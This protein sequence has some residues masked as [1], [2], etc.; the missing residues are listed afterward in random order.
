MK[1]I[2]NT[3]LSLSLAIVLGTTSTAMAGAFQLF[4]QSAA[5]LGT[6]QATAAAGCNDPATEYTN[7]AGMVCFKSPTVTQGLEIIGLNIKY[8]G[9]TATKTA[10]ITPPPVSGTTRADATVAI[11]NIHFVLPIND[12]LFYGAGFSVPFGLETNYSEDSVAAQYATKSQMQNLNFSQDLAYAFN[13]HFSF[14]AGI[15]LQQFEGTFNT[16]ESVASSMLPD[17]NHATSNAI[18]WH[19][20]VLYQINSRTRFGL[21][22]HAKVTQKAKGTGTL[23]NDKTRTSIQATGPVSTDFIL[24]AW[25]SFGAYHDINK[26]WAIMSTVNYTYW[27]SVKDLALKG[28]L[29]VGVPSTITVPLN[30]RNTFEISIGTTYK[31]TKK[32]TGKFGLGYDETPTNDKNRELRLPDSDRINVALGAHYQATERMSLDVGY[33]HSFMK[34]TSVYTTITLPNVPS[35]GIVDNAYILNGSF[36]NSADIVGVQLTYKF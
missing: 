3:T 34:K 28:V 22:Y 11:P 12:K 20:G 29:F 13:S 19:A 7:P 35:Q 36:N 8:S 4:E 26:R 31:L 15:D 5:G 17:D 9:S 18:G 30:F 27:S 33:E 21:A 24:P 2:K 32:W 14:G 23:Y 16:I 6:G 10:G 1:N 25:L